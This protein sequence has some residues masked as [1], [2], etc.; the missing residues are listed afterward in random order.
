MTNVK[1]IQFHMSDSLS[2]D[3]S[4]VFKNIQTFNFTHTWNETEKN[5]AWVNMSLKTIT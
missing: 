5:Q 1:K 4:Q 2:M 3:K